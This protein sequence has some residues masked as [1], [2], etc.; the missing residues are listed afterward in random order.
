MTFSFIHGLILPGL[1]ESSG[2]LDGQYIPKNLRAFRGHV[3]SRVRIC[4]NTVCLERENGVRNL[5]SGVR[6]CPRQ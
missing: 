6:G 5:F 2:T 3:A 4:H 1:D